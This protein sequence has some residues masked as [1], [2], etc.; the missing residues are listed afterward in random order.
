MD[1]IG[2]WKI[3]KVGFFNPE[4]G[5]E[6]KTI[7]EIMTMEETEEVIQA[8]EMS[9]TFL[10]VT[11]DGKMRI[12]TIVPP[13]AIEE[14]KAN[15]EEVPLNDDG[16]VTIQE[17]PWKEENGELFYFAGG[18]CEIDGESIDPWVKIELDKDGLLVMTMM[19]FEKQ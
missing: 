15:G 9:Q 1:I 11:E 5:F 4:S 3:K 2:T 6:M 10:K 18:E 8:K 14:A 12:S 13:E 19:A 7:D 17:M 16:T